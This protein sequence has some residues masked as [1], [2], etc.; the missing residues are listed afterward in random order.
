MTAPFFRERGVSRQDHCPHPARPPRRGGG[1]D[2]RGP[3]P[4]L[5]RLVSHDRRLPHGRRRLDRDLTWLTEVQPCFRDKA[6]V[7][8][9]TRS[10]EIPILTKTRSIRR[11]Y[12]NAGLDRCLAG[13]QGAHRRRPRSL[14]FGQ[15]T[16]STCTESRTTRRNSREDTT[17][18]TSKNRCR[19]TNRSRTWLYTVPM[20]IPPTDMHTDRVRRLRPGAIPMP[21]LWAAIPC[22]GA[23]FHTKKSLWKLDGPIS[24]ASHSA[25]RSRGNSRAQLAD[26]VAGAGYVAIGPT[27]GNHLLS[28]LS[29]DDYAKMAGKASAS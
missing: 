16:W 17:I 22:E 1:P 6:S 25:G 27:L 19:C 7:W 10:D 11:S 12:A 2:G 14:A 3:V 20:H 15:A 13:R 24:H 21:G 23:Y 28:K 4:R 9:L 18:R 5:R 26:R 8:R 29:L